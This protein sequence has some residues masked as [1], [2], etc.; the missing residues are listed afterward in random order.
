MTS[1]SACCS[2]TGRGARVQNRRLLTRARLTFTF[3]A[4]SSPLYYAT[5]LQVS[6]VP[7]LSLIFAQ[8]LL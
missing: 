3:P 8:K 2:W 1:E 4:V 5:D 6:E 7:W